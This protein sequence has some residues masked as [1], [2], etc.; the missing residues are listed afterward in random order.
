MLV[1]LNIEN[2]A[3]IDKMNLH[4]TSGLNIITGETGAGKSILIEAIGIILGSRSSKDLIQTGYSKAFLEA[5]FYIEDSKSIKPILDEYSIKIDKD[6]LLIIS[7]EIY[8]KSPSLS[9]VNGKSVNLTMLGNI[10]KKLVDIFGQ[11]EHQSLLDLSNHQKLVDTFGNDEFNK[12]KSKIKTDYENLFAEKRKLKDLSMDGRERDREIDVLKFQIQEIEDANLCEKEDR[13]LENNYK[14][15]SNVKE[16]CS[17][18]NELVGFISEDDSERGNI[19]EL[20]NK[21]SFNLNKIKEFDENISKLYLR[22]E[23]VKFELEDLNR[24]FIN[25]MENID[26]DDEK[27]N[28]LENRLNTVNTLKRKYGNSIEDVLKFMEHAAKRLE[29]LLNHEKE[30]EIIN[31]NILEIEKL[32][33]INSKKISDQRKEISRILEKKIKE[34]LVI[35]NMNK[36]DF[37]VDFERTREFTSEGYDKIEFLI[38]TNLGEEL[39]PLSK[40]ASGGE[41]SRIMLAFKSILAYYDQIPTMI[42]DEIDTGISGRTAQIVGEKI[43]RISESHQVICISHLPQIAALADSHYSINKVIVDNKTR[44]RVDKLTYDGRVKEMARLLGGV[45]LTETTLKHASEMIEMSKKIKL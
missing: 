39:K 43:Y 14:K 26:Y 40:I 21:S 9:K 11:H 19:L 5:I 8:L 20:I 34:E 22:L 15:L 45:N 31:K 32:L 10:T 25:Y 30:L 3:I 33:E 13:D 44:T 36:V 24:E 42:F 1:E 37:K 2:F 38:S 35:L 16:I 18:I 7:K 17:T 12:L 4:F 23:N 6:N 27:L 41:M 28:Y 29:A